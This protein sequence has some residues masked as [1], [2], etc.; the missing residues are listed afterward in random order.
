MLTPATGALA[1]YFSWEREAWVEILADVDGDEREHFLPLESLKSYFTMCD[2]WHRKNLDC[3]LAEV[4]QTDLPPI[5]ADLILR[6][7]AAVFC[8]LL[9]INRA[10]HIEHFACFEE[11][12]DR[13]LPFDITRPPRHFPRH[14]EFL[15]EFCAVQKRYCVPIFDAHMLHKHF[16]SQRLLPITFRR[17]LNTRGTPRTAI[18][19]IYKLNNHI[20]TAA[21]K[22]NFPESSPTSEP[23]ETTANT[24]VVETYAAGDELSAY[25]RKISLLRPLKNAKGLI[26]FYG[27]YEHRDRSHI[28]L[29]YADKG[30]LDHFFQNE[31]PPSRGDDIVDFW[32]NLLQLAKGLRA[33]HTVKE[34]HYDVSPANILVLSK[35]VPSPCH[36][37]FK[38]SCPGLPLPP[39]HT[40]PAAQCYAP[41]TA[42]THRHGGANAAGAD[43]WSLGRILGEAAFWVAEG[44]KGVLDYRQQMAQA[45]Y[46]DTNAYHD[47][48]DDDDD[49]GEQMFQTIFDI[50]GELEH[51]LR[52]SDH[53]TKDILDTLVDEML[54]DE[55][56]PSMETVTRQA[57]VVISRARQK[58]RASTSSRRSTCSSRRSRSRNPTRSNTPPP[59]LPLPSF[60]ADA[61]ADSLCSSLRFPQHVES[62]RMHVT[63]HS[64]AISTPASN[65]ASLF[66]GVGSD[67]SRV[68]GDHVYLGGIESRTPELEIDAPATSWFLD[69]PTT[70][71]AITPLTSPPTSVHPSQTPALDVKQSPCIHDGSELAIETTPMKTYQIMHDSEAADA[72]EP[73]LTYPSSEVNKPLTV[74]ETSLMDHPIGQDQSA[75][76]DAQWGRQTNNDEVRLG[77]ALQTLPSQEY[78]LKFRKS[79]PLPRFAGPSSVTL[80]GNSLV[81]PTPKS[82]NMDAVYSNRDRL[83]PHASVGPRPSASTNFSYCRPHTGHDSQLPSRSYHSRKAVESIGEFSRSPSTHSISSVAFEVKAPGVEN[84][85]HNSVRSSVSSSRTTTSN[86]PS[87]G[88]TILSKGRRISSAMNTRR[89]S[90]LS[91]PDSDNSFQAGTT[92][93]LSPLCEP[94]NCAAEGQGDYLDVDTCRQW[95]KLSKAN[96]K[97]KQQPP[98]LPGTEHL[99]A[100]EQRDHI[101]IVDDSDSM[102]P[103][104][105]N[106]C[107]VFEGLSYMV[108]G[109]SPGGTELFFTVSCDTRRRKGTQDLCQYLAKHRLQKAQT[110]IARRLDLQLAAYRMKLSSMKRGAKEVRPVSYYILSNGDWTEASMAELQSTLERTAGLTQ[111]LGLQQQILVSFVRFGESEGSAGMINR[112]AWDGVGVRVASTARTGNVWEMLRGKDD[113]DKCMGTRSWQGEEASATGHRARELEETEQARAKA[114]ATSTSGSR[115]QETSAASEIA[116]IFELA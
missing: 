16:E 9:N 103:H 64:T 73:T 51:H 75:A 41:P 91:L 8:I 36:W 24:F 100:L 30:T 86:R 69:S 10:Q 35:G 27:S 14:P 13:R 82:T 111:K 22:C 84:T 67:S 34:A 48:D 45:L 50:H 39:L 56:P 107:H 15:S 71:S 98:L 19:G 5:D 116:G 66:S 88:S 94:A 49:D 92:S 81:P 65:R 58:L 17:P 99:E 106:V 26:S 3:I 77:G 108:K 96:K 1:E 12:S 101:F 70:D 53:I 109:M 2:D 29:E 79:P 44:W 40:T 32:E 80:P 102:G 46:S 74:S 90:L 21:A 112:L 28:L 59:P 87:I 62:W 43:I 97:K 63:S 114:A 11:L 31:A 57:D 7:H 4:F 83:A 6:D 105:M 54:W 18:I 20:T 89:N 52:R 78:F 25:T 42:L 33:I 38:F 61:K 72:I 55:T 95:K 104:W 115:S 85:R 60:M 113:E 76:L 37:Q 93:R 110:N 47:D 68:S 23:F